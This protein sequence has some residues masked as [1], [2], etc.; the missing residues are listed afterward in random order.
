MPRHTTPVIQ[1]LVVI[2]AEMRHE[3]LDRAFCWSTNL[4][5]QV[6]RMPN[7]RIAELDTGQ[8]LELDFDVSPGKHKDVT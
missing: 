1:I 6:R 4:V 3:R 7:L 2:S 5:V 8:G